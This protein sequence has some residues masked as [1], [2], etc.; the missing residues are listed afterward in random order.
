MGSISRWTSGLLLATLTCAVAI[1]A[2]PAKAPVFLGPAITNP[3][4][5]PDFTLHDQNGRVVRLSAERGK[6]VMITFLYTH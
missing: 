1:S 2:A 5:A 4:L 6:V 3:S